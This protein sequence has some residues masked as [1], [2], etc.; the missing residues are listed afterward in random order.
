M[1][2]GLEAA[3]VEEVP[4]GDHGARHVGQRLLRRGARKWSTRGQTMVKLWSKSGQT[5]VPCVRGAEGQPARSP[6]HA[7]TFDHDLT[8]G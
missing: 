2:A 1:C 4:G 5:G 3:D 8:T 6:L 7:H